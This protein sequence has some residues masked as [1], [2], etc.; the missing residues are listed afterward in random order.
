MS[1]KTELTIPGYTES[2]HQPGELE[3][4]YLKV[5]HEGGTI[6]F[7]VRECYVKIPCTDLSALRRLLNEL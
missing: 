7:Q 4:S 6:E 3:D 5:T 1:T 2:P